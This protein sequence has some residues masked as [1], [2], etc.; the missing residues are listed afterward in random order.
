MMRITAWLLLAA[1][2][3]LS[4]VPPGWRPVSGLPHGVEHAAIFLAMGL[5][6]ARAYPGHRGA[7]ALTA[8]TFVGVLEVL[9][10]IV[11]GRHARMSDFVVD[12]ASV[13]IG[14][15]AAGLFARKQPA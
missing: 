8:I 1:V 11:P 15:A 7:L 5:A 6:F 3:T 4:L 12:A 9:Q 2:I 10:R 13:C 14:I